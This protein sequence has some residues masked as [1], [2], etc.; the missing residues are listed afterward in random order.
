MSLNVDEETVD[1]PLDADATRPVTQ[2]VVTDCRSTRLI[3]STPVPVRLSIG[4]AAKSNATL[5]E[6]SLNES[7]PP[8]TEANAYERERTS[9]FGEMLESE[10]VS[11]TAVQRNREACGS[12]FESDTA[13]DR[14]M[15][16]AGNWN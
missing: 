4:E 14:E 12:L 6:T 9:S 13:A 1:A 10:R 3:C 16:E 15:R 2:L 8:V 5:H 7:V 11:V